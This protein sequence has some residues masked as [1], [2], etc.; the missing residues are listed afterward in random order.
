MCRIALLFII[1]AAASSLY[2]ESAV[3][4]SPDLFATVRLASRR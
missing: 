2:A 3:S 4:G 1:V